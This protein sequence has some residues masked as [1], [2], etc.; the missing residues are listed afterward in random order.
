[1]R[2][3][4]NSPDPAARVGRRRIRDIALVDVP[5]AEQGVNYGMAALW[6]KGRPLLGFTA[7]RD[8]LSVFSFSPAAVEA[9][10]EHLPSDVVSKGTVRFTPDRPLPEQVVRGLIRTRIAEIDR[11]R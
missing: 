1:V 6:Y 9:V 10:R 8:H 4:K 2:P 11:S 7:A 5:D 3:A